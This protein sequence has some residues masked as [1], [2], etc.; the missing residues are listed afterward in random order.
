MEQLGAMSA[1][2]HKPTFRNV[3]SM[4][5]LPPKAD[6]GTQLCD[7]RFVPKADIPDG[8]SMLDWFS[9]STQNYGWWFPQRIKRERGARVFCTRNAVA[10]PATVSGESLADLPLRVTDTL[11]KAA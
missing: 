8:R 5:A 1:L 10:A 11:G 9:G 2:G 4:S 7:V 6:I 3:R